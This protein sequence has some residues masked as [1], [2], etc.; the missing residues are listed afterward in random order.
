MLH[1]NHCCDDC[2]LDHF[3]NCLQ[4]GKPEECTYDKIPRI[5]HCNVCT[6]AYSDH[7]LFVVNLDTNEAW[8]ETCYPFEITKDTIITCYAK[9]MKK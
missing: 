5:L 8:H 9:R 4:L 2:G 7:D 6:M 1:P 3:H